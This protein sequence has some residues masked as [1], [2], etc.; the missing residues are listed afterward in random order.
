VIREIR[1]MKNVTIS[2][3]EELARWLRVEAAEADVSISR[4]LADL[5]ADRKAAVDRREVARLSYLSRGGANISTGGRYPSRD[6][7]H[8]R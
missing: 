6:E 2:M 5:V 7:L 4:Y 8:E 3:S 1:D